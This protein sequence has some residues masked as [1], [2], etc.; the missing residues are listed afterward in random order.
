MVP[1]GCLAMLKQLV[2]KYRVAMSKKL[3]NS[4]RGPSRSL[5]ARLHLE[6]LESRCLL[7]ASTLDLAYSLGNLNGVGQIAVLGRI[8]PGANGGG[9]VD[10]YQ[11]TLTQT[12]KVDLHSLSLPSS[13]LHSLLSVYNDDPY[14][15]SDPQDIIGHRLLSQTAGA[16]DQSLAAGTYW[17]AVSGAGNA[18][19]NPF[20]ADSG[21]AGSTGDFEL[22]VQ[23]TDLPAAV[24][25]TS[26]VLYSNPG[27]GAVVP[28]APLV[29]RIDFSTQPDPN[30]IDLSSTQLLW[31][32]TSNLAD[33]S[34]QMISANAYYSTAANELQLTPS[35]PL[36]AGYYGVFLSDGS[37]V[38]RFQVAG[39]GPDD[40]AATAHNLGSLTPG[41]LVQV[42]GAIGN[43]PDPLL[44]TPA[45][46][47]NLYHFQIT[48]AGRY[49]F[50][51][52]VFAGRI[53]SA[54]DSGV[55]LYE[56]N[57]T[58]QS[59]DFIDGNDNTLNATHSTNGMSPLYTDSAL[60]VGLTA[61]DYYVAVSGGGSPAVPGADN[62]PERALGTL[63]GVNG[64][65]DPNF[66]DSGTN[67]A[68][69]GDYVLNLT[70]QADNDPPQVVSAT[71]GN[72][73][74]LTAPPTQLTV[75]FSESMNLQMLA[76]QAFQQTSVEGFASTNIGGQ[77]GSPP[78]LAT[79]GPVYVEG[80]DGTKYYPRM[81]SYDDMTHQAQFLMLDGLANGTYQLH[82][83]GSLGLADLAGNSLVGNDPSGD[84]VVS[85]A[86]NGPV[87]GTN[88]DPLV[89]VD[90]ESN[91]TPL[92]PQDLGVLFPHELQ[93]TVTVTR[94]FAANPTSAPTDTGDFYQFQ[95]LQS[96]A[97]SIVL[98]GVDPT[99][100]VGLSLYDTAGN[101]V[102]SSISGN[103]MEVQLDP[104]TYVVGV[105]GWTPDVAGSIT[106]QLSLG[107]ASN[108]DNPP[109]LT[110]GAA[111]ALQS[112]LYT[113]A[114]SSM[115]TP[116]VL[117]LPSTGNGPSAFGNGGVTQVSYITLPSYAPQVT[118]VIP[119]G[120]FQQF[121][122]A[123][124]GS[125]SGTLVAGP[126]QVKERIQFAV[127]DASLALALLTGLTVVD[128][129]DSAGMSPLA[130]NIEQI[131]T[132]STVVRPQ[133]D[134]P[135][136]Q[137]TQERLRD[138]VFAGLKGWERLMTNQPTLPNTPA[139]ATIDLREISLSD[140]VASTSDQNSDYAVVTT[141]A[142]D[143]SKAVAWVAA[144]AAGLYATMLA[145]KQ[146]ALASKEPPRSTNGESEQTATE[147]L[148]HELLS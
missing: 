115:P 16:F 139:S 66:T 43:N 101:V 18:Y 30:S 96:K 75:Q 44:A 65:F 24:N 141:E 111:P 11:F 28:S 59:L 132:P 116:P 126:L 33:P 57:T 54:L 108:P 20:I 124:L 10:W 26:T 53:G 107:L 27:N 2:S 131:K 133:A 80:A 36:Q 7:S 118:L 79:I 12:A 94:D 56:W 144:V 135:L 21:Y 76:Y 97:L 40:T 46:Q 98:N 29:V 88:G 134:L 119:S 114:T 138:L 35:P 147:E 74:T 25:T 70:V 91:D 129:P 3:R 69:V 14:N 8:V 85:F 87:R 143:L 100:G 67:G 148:Y 48:G 105:S 41:N 95:V 123:P 128:L 146:K 122:T 93:S 34:A 109:P 112:R 104:G 81:Q 32:P 130:S 52:E 45:A 37:Q 5:Y 68:T 78:S 140:P 17:V 120:V 82:L 50:S 31:S 42:A 39:T 62:V 4:R 71:P 73:T 58:T 6:T 61:G 9:E 110:T 63:P 60:T 89:R 22:T 136:A 99:S 64:I 15:Y 1:L 102:S 92:T 117:V 113:I 47:V 72:G 86:V 23:A 84:Y 127:P 121:G 103:V 19:F 38:L 13:S 145:W 125:F 137:E 51:A 106:Y 83:S 55:S 49:A 90:Q 77:V 142:S